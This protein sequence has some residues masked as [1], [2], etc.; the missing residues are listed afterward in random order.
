MKISVEISMYPLNKS[1]G[2]PILHFIEK[3]KKRTDVVVKSNTMS[4]Q[5]FGEYDA[6]MTL[7]Q[8]EIKPAFETSDTVV[9][10]LKIV[11]QPLD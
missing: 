2:I 8:H 1:Y 7:L 6:V 9:M 4:T 10:I 11:N 3:I 5:I